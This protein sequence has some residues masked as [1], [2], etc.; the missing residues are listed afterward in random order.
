MAKFLIDDKLFSY[1][2]DLSCLTFSDDE[3]KHLMEDLQKT[4]NGIAHLTDLNTD[5]VPLCIQPFDH[6]NV[7]REDAVRTSLDREL[8]LKN[9]PLKNE[10]MFVAPKTLE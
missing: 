2:E 9:A 6:V 5:D 1:L 10:K 8:V 4:M 3:K 7:F